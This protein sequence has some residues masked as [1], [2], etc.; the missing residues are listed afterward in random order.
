MRDWLRADAT[1]FR[2]PL[3]LAAITVVGGLLLNT[4]VSVEGQRH[5]VQLEEKRNQREVVLELMRSNNRQLMLEKLKILNSTGL[6]PDR[7]GSLRKAVEESAL[8]TVVIPCGDLTTP[9]PEE[10][11]RVGDKLTGNAQKDVRTVAASA[12]LLRAYAQGLRTVLEGCMS[13]GQ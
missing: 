3:V 5:A 12:V 2:H 4:C 6:L 9:L 1:P 8:T 11:P 13:G 10:P 7:D